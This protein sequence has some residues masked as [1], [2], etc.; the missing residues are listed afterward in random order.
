M[1]TELKRAYW[2]PGNWPILFGLSILRLLSFLPLRVLR[3]IGAAI[4]RLLYKVSSRRRHIA[5]VN[6]QLCFPELSPEKHRQ[7]VIEVFENTGMGLLEL[8]WCWYASIPRLKKSFNISGLEHIQKAQ[9]R[10]QGVLLLCFHQTTLELGGS[11][12][13]TVQKDIVV[14]Y[15]PNKNPVFENAMR[16]GRARLGEPVERTH[17]RKIVKSLKKKQVVWYAA[18]QNY[19]IKQ[20]VFVPFFGIPAA[21]ITAT[22]WF[23]KKGKAVVIPMT[24]RRSKKGMDITLHPPLENFPSGDDARDA[25]T[26]MAFLEDYLKKYPADYMWVHRRF[27]TRP[28]GEAR[29]Y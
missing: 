1:P 26:N 10:G 4:G 16:A 18:D 23:A 19:G 17:V 7:L 29:L 21:T 13:A 27:K 28:E 9:Q 6:L 25:A 11:M 14:M 24:H 12:L 15:R 8:A 3:H 5:E 20:G 22:S 2:K